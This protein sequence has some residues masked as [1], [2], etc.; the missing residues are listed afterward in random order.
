M[1]TPILCRYQNVNKNVVLILSYR[2][3]D[4]FRFIIYLIVLLLLLLLADFPACIICVCEKLLHSCSVGC[5]LQPH[6]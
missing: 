4:F 5:I 3:S 6:H 1:T 2:S